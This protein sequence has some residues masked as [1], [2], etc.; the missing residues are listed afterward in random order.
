MKKILSFAMV[1]TLLLLTL[2]SCGAANMKEAASD[3]FFASGMK[4]GESYDYAYD[5]GIILDSS[6]SSKEEAAISERK[7]IKN[8]L[9]RMQTKEYEEFIL[10]LN[11]S[12]SHYGGY[13][14]TQKENGNSYNSVS[15]RYSYIVAKIPAENLE[16][17][18]S[19]VSELC[20]VTYRQE[21]V[22]DVTEAYIDIESRIAVL[23]AEESSLLAMLESAQN[24]LDDEKLNYSEVIDT[25]MYI[26]D[27]LLS[28]QSD[29][30]S[31]KAQL[32]SLSANVT[33]STVTMEINEVERFVAVETKVGL[34]EE[35]GEK[36]SDNLY[37]IGQ[38]LRSF[39]VWL[40]ISLPYILIW[41]VIITIFVIIVRKVIKN[42]K[43][44]D[45]RVKSSDVNESGRKDKKGE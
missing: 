30:A 21:N 19:G 41:A 12:I 4:P 18:C 33:Y 34:W 29:L 22:S 40:V 17:F 27:K 31:M 24:H 14:S 26:K 25:M 2:C 7:Q 5:S 11:A 8:V 35:I 23:E 43:K 15:N 10:S 32:K 13:I 37:Y 42:R 36:L 44:R 20:N 28:V 16:E 45:Y 6:M 3:N 1:L 39:F 9:L 38:D